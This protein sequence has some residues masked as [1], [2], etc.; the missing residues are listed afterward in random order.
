MCPEA[1][2]V[3]QPSLLTLF[4]KPNFNE[5]NN[6]RNISYQP[7][8]C[9]CGPRPMTQCDSLSLKNAALVASHVMFELDWLCDPCGVALTSNHAI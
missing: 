6:N 8:Q 9:S 4:D 1:R 2:Q 7:G 3:N 5:T